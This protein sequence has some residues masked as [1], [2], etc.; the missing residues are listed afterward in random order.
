MKISHP[1]SFFT[2][3]FRISKF[4]CALGVPLVFAACTT[5]GPF[6]RTTAST[7]PVETTGSTGGAI[8]AVRVYETSDRLYVSGGIRKSFGRHIPSAA[9][10]DVQLIDRAGRVIAERQDDIEPVHPKI[11]G[12]MT[13]RSSYVAGFPADEARR[14]AKIVVRYHMD[15]HNP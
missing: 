12:G 3:I 9:H 15:G 13:G 1:N 8:S 11:S 6:R 7:L 14:A 2:R 5:A 4:V 10:V